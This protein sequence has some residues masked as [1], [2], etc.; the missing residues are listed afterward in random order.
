MI[1]GRGEDRIMSRTT[2]ILAA[3]AAGV[4]AIGPG[5][6]AARAGAIPQQHIKHHLR[7]DGTS[8][9]R[10]NV[11]ARSGL[12]VTD[13]LAT[14][15]LTSTG[16]VQFGGTLT[17][18]GAAS[19][20]GLNGGTGLIVTTGGLQGGTLVVSGDA[21]L[22]GGLTVNKRVAATGVDVGAGGL[23]VSGGLT[24]ASTS[25]A[26]SARAAARSTRCQLPRAATST[27]IMPP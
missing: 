22:G 14:D 13:G 20:D 10:G 5:V 21:T 15:F 7:V 11:T 3:L 2:I 23:S 25:M 17:I 1:R 24:G 19:A 18:A 12:R 9:L 16:P 27:S 8:D 6:G 4:L 26:R